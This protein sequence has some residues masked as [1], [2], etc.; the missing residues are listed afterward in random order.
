[1]DYKKEMDDKEEE[2]ETIHVF[3]IFIFS[4]ISILQL[5]IE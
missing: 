3:P 4:L 2:E 5:K 1:M